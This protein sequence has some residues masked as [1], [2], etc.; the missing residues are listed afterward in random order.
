MLG[1]LCA[2][3]AASHP[4][5]SSVSALALWHVMH[6][7]EKGKHIVRELINRYPQ[8]ANPTGASGCGKE[9]VQHEGNYDSLRPVSY[10]DQYLDGIT[11]S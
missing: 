7:S 3:Y 2:N 6:H 11:I 9:N 5:V 1:L 10:E 8:Q 4:L